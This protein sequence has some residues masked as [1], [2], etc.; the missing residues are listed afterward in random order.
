MNRMWGT[1]YEWS[2]IQM[3]RVLQSKNPDRPTRQ[4]VITDDTAV[5]LRESL[6]VRSC[7]RA[8]GRSGVRAYGDF[9]GL[10]W[11][12]ALARVLWQRH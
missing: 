5:R 9:A 1:R 11:A 4:Q 7:A 12:A 8:L 6:F 10:G 2:A 3:L